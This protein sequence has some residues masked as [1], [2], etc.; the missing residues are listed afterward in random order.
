MAEAKTKATQAFL[1]AL[2]VD[3]IAEARR[4]HNVQ[5]GG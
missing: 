5:S 1:E 2:V 3:S 4:R